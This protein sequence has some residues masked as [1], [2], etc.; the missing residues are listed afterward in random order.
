MKAIQYLVE[1][2]INGNISHAKEKAKNFSAK[3][4]REAFIEYAGYSF[5]KATLAADVLKHE[6]NF[7]EYCDAL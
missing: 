1:T 7:Q 6:G 2:F 3:T 4:I 5:R